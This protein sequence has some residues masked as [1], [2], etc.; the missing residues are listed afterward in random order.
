MKVGARRRARDE[1][2]EEEEEEEEVV[3]TA[4]A[5]AEEKECPSLLSVMAFVLPS[6]VLNLCHLGGHA[7]GRLGIR[8]SSMI[9]GS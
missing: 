1:E 5:A 6:L 9:V 8:L 7:S 4:A 2:E 3:E